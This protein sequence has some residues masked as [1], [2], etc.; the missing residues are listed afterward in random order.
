M[1]LPTVPHN[2]ES[3]DFSQN[4]NKNSLQATRRLKDSLW[5]FHSKTWNGVYYRYNTKL[6]IEEDISTL[7]GL[8][9]IDTRGYNHNPEVVRRREDTIYQDSRV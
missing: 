9:K 1:L 5:E 3:M 8:E 7:L 2:W 4:L 6:R